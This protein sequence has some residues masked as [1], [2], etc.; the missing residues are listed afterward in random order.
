MSE[1]K[2]KLEFESIR[3]PNGE[4]C[5]TIYPPGEFLKGS[6]AANKGWS[7]FV[8][9]SGNGERKTL[10]EAKKFLLERAI[11]YCDRRIQEALKEIIHYG[12]EKQKLLD[13]GLVPK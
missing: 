4:V 10:E 5:L 1:S 9:G 6:E 11:Q 7:V 12:V 8:G 13:Q 2:K 3:Q